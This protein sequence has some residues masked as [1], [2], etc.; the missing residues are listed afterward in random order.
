MADPA[1]K[2]VAGTD[3]LTLAQVAARAEVSPSTV[4]RWLARG[5]V[6]GFDGRWTPSALAYV[7]VANATLDP[8]VQK[9]V[10]AL[11]AREAPR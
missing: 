1:E 6:P 10:S 7:R 11:R 5:L 3:E 4:K 2:S 8:M 9:V